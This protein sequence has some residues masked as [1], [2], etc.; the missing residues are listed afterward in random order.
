MMKLA[1]WGARWLAL[2]GGLVLAVLC[3]MVVVSV[4]A[5]ALGGIGLKP[6]P[7]DFELVEMGTAIAVFFFLPWCYL[8]NGHAMVDLVY[9]HL[10]APMQ[11]FVSILSDVLMLIV[12][13]VLTWRLGIAV[14][15]K[16]GERETSFILQIPLWMPQAIG[17]FGAAAGC[18]VY[19]AKTIAQLGGTVPDADGG[20]GHA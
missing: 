6:V 18:L 11:R 1:D 20:G 5:R 14:G 4:S 10:P 16:F 3:L 8:R 17:L 7:G 13:V 12:W 19:L 2:A 9:L 15:D